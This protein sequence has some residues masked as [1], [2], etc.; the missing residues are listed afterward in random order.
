MRGLAIPAQAEAPRT[1]RPEQARAT[2]DPM[3]SSGRGK[4]RNE[5]RTIRLERLHG[6]KAAHSRVPSAEEKE[7]LRQEA[8]EARERYRQE[9]L[10]KGQ[11]LGD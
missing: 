1:E 2:E 3:G 6:P 10:M 11:R 5:T 9:Q 8:L 4:F 7:K